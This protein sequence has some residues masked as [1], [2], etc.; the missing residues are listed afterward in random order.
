VKAARGLHGSSVVVKVS[1]D[2]RGE[3][4]IGSAWSRE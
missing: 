4:V 3:C 2:A 1:F